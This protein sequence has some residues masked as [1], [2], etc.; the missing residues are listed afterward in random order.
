VTHL[1]NISC[2]GILSRIRAIC[3]IRVLYLLPHAMALTAGHG[4]EVKNSTSP[5]WNWKYFFVSGEQ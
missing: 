2:D 5:E 4:E 3:L 1:M